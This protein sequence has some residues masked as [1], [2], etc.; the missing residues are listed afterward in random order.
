M[1]WL[2]LLQIGKN[3]GVMV[4]RHGCGQLHT[5]CSTSVTDRHGS[6]FSCPNPLVYEFLCGLIFMGHPVIASVLF[7]HLT[8]LFGLY[9]LKFKMNDRIFDK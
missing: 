8:S 7:Y 9:L 2:Y 4:V 6:A 3:P 1:S 5:H